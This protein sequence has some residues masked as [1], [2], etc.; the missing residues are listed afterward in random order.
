[1]GRDGPRKGKKPP[2][3]VAP[4][5]EDGDALQERRT[6]EVEALKAIFMVLFCSDDHL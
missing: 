4:T 1:M 5:A 3:P 6:L 2:V